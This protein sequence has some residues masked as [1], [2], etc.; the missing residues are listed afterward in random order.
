MTKY[1]SG[2]IYKIITNKT[3]DVYVGS[4]IKELSKRYCQHVYNYKNKINNKKYNK[5]LSSYEILKHG[6]CGCEIKL[7]E[8]YKCNSSRELHKREE[9][10]IN[11]TKYC[12]NTK[13]A[14]RTQDEIF[15]DKIAGISLYK[16]GK[17]LCDKCFIEGHYYPYNKDKDCYKLYCIRQK[18]IKFKLVFTC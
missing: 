1:K 4:T 11:N 18:I 3:K 7:I 17:I 14:Y 10:W 15:K 8:E 16:Y 13:K 6:E 5:K 2:K 9:Y 12:V